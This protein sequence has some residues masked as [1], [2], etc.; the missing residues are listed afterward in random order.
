MKNATQEI[1]AGSLPGEDD[2]AGMVVRLPLEDSIEP[3]A[4]VS[5]MRLPE[6]EIKISN[7]GHD[8]GKFAS[9]LCLVVESSAAPRE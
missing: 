9:S 6:K 3:C 7:S 4:S 1:G 5:R 8:S 2:E